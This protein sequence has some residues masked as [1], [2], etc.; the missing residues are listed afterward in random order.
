MNQPAWKKSCARS[1]SVSM[2]EIVLG[3]ALEV[4]ID[5]RGKTPKKLGGD[6]VR[7]GVP[8]ASALLVRNGCLNLEDARYVSPE[9]H[10]RWMPIPTRRH[11]VI[12]TSEA[13]L[14]RVALVDSDQPLVLGQRLF[15]LRG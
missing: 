7:M 11:D 2:S 15:G 13:P 9:M 4:I 5:H 14:G 6:F 10:K 8:V 1:W 12:L 3:D